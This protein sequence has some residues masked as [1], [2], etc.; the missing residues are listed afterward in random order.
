MNT[1]QNEGIAGLK[2]ITKKNQNFELYKLW[3]SPLKS[4]SI[5]VHP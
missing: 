4:V 5:R 1:D 2:R 3:I